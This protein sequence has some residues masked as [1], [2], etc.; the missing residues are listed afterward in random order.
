MY[1]FSTFDGNKFYEAIK[2]KDYDLLISY[3]ICAIRCDPAFKK[4]E[5]PHIIKI[6]EKE[7]PEIFKEEVKL[8]YEVELPKSEWNK[9]YFYRQLLRL[10]NNFC[11]KRLDY[12]KKVGQAI[13]R[14]PVRTESVKPAINQTAMQNRSRTAQTSERPVSNGQNNRKTLPKGKNFPKAGMLWAAGI[15]AIVILVVLLVNLLIK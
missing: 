3:F 4:E 8:D 7:V 10:Q 1:D 5:I 6:F 13:F 15:L 11:K 14:E 12:L 9:D 2:N